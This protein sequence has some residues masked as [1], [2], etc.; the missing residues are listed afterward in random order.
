MGG[1]VS[2]F[3]QYLQIELVTRLAKILNGGGGKFDA[4]ARSAVLVQ[5]EDLAAS[6]K[7]KASARSMGGLNASTQAHVRHLDRLLRKSLLIE[8]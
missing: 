5:L 8:H 3:R 2:S 1:D 6:M 4:L 7:D